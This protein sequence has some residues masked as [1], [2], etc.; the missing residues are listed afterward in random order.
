[1]QPRGLS[2]GNKLLKQV[3]EQEHKRANQR[4][5]MVISLLKFEITP[6]D[7]YVSVEVTW[8]AHQEPTL[9]RVSF[10]RFPHFTSSYFFPYGGEA[11]LHHNLGSSRAMPTCLGGFTSKSNKCNEDCFT[12]LKCLSAHTEDLTQLYLRFLTNQS[13]L[14]KRCRGEVSK[15]QGCVFSLVEPAT[16]KGGSGE[17]FYTIH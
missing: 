14:T 9:N 16:S 10:N 5:N 12:K 2:N 4:M 17:S 7:P 11:D 13:N 6:R 15:A 1:M 8:V 3:G